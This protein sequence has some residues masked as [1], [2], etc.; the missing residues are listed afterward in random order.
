MMNIFAVR[1]F[2]NVAPAEETG[3]SELPAPLDVGMPSPAKIK[4]VGVGGGGVK[5][6]E[7]HD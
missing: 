3:Y 2:V 7:P 1:E 5:R 4:V 6:R